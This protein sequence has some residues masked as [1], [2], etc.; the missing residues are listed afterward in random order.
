MENIFAAPKSA[1]V[2]LCSQPPDPSLGQ[3]FICFLSLEISF[4]F[5]VFLYESYG[6]YTFV[7][8]A[9]HVFET[10]PCGHMLLIIYFLAEQHSTVWVQCGLFISSPEAG[11][12][13]CV[14]GRG[15]HCEY[16]YLF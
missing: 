3:P 16:G 1:P 11:H 6:V 7:S 13:S 14:R 12:L 9:W 4:A 5:P 2:P 10:H 15:E 8:S